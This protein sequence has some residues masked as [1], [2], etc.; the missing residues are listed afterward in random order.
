LI[1]DT[2]RKP[3]VVLLTVPASIALSI[4]LLPLVSV[5]LEREFAK[6]AFSPFV[7]QFSVESAHTLLS[8]V[9]T[10]AMTAL[11]L[12]YSLVLVV[13]TLAAG[14][15]GP[16]LLQRFT[17]ELVN[18]VTAGILGGTFLYAII[19]LLFTQPDFVPKI[20]IFGAVLLA[21][22][23]VLQLIYFVRHVSQS[24]SVDDEIAQ[25]TARITRQFHNLQRTTDT[26]GETPDKAE[27][28]HEICAATAGY[29]G[30]FDEE[31]LLETA[32]EHELM[33]WVEV[34]SGGFVLAGEQVARVAG[35]ADEDLLEAIRKHITIESSRSED[36]SPEF[37]INLLVEIALRALS[38]GINDTYTALAVVNSFSNAF[39]K[40]AEADTAPILTSD[41]TGTPR[42]ILPSMSMSELLGQAFHP[43]RLATAQ[44]I[45]MAQGFARSLARLYVVGG[46]EMRKLITEHARLLM[47]TMESANHFDHDLQRVR[48]CFPKDLAESSKDAP[49]S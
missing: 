37:S 8:V 13:F 41:D 43:I 49:K 10:G 11:S 46:K 29:V 40:I 7:L 12:A 9:A 32:S 18:Q 48:S 22:I 23:S 6:E 30:W 42:L 28:T 21:I 15:I 2:L 27:F 19:T 45:L 1:I 5:F 4:G 36:R 34:P 33:I 38:P 14:N 31:Y 35:E 3:F 16:R 26:D 39:A 47:Q 25:I 17:S 20:T 24:V 44:N